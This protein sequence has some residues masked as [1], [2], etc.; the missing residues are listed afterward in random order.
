MRYKVVWIPLSPRN[1]GGH[2]GRQ[3]ERGRAK[4]IALNVRET[5][6]AKAATMLASQWDL[7]LARGVSVMTKFRLTRRQEL[8]LG[9][10][11]A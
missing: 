7:R 10:K 2:A 5:K 6:C 8:E 4:G 9:N 1:D 3:R 11:R